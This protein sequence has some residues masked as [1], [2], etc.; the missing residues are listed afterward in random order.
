MKPIHSE[1]DY[2][3]GIYNCVEED[4]EELKAVAQ[5]LFEYQANR[6]KCYKPTGKPE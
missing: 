2:P 4:R 3:L 1:G 6:C 5:P